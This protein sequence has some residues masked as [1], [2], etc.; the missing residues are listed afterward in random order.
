MAE[1]G[2]PGAEKSALNKN[3]G[4]IDPNE[5]HATADKAYFMEKLNAGKPWTR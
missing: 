1:S 5:F 3:G 4:D 2:D